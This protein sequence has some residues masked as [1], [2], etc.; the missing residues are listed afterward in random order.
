MTRPDAARSAG[1]LPAEV[2][3]FVGRRGETAAVTRLLGAHRLL[4]LTGG[5]GVGKTRLA[6]RVAAGLAPAFRDGVWLVELGPLQADM[7]L[8]ERVAEAVG[9]PVE[10]ARA[11]ERELAGFLGGKDLL[12]VLDN[13]EHVVEACRVL[14]SGLLGA[15]AE[16]RIVA[17]S[18]QPL[19]GA[20]EWLFEVPPLPVLDGEQPLSA[21]QVAGDGA[22]RLFT[23]RAQAALPG[24]TVG[25]ANQDTIVRLC[26]RLGGIPLAIELAAVHV[27]AMP[28]ERILARLEDQYLDVLG[29]GARAS[30]PRL[31]T[32]QASIDSSFD[33]CSK[34]EQRV[35]AR[36]SVFRGGFDLD[37]AQRVCSGAGVDRDEV[38]RVLAGLANKSVLTRCLVDGAGRYEM[39]EPLREYGLER[40]RAS[41]EAPMVRMRHRDHFAELAWQADQRL[42]S[43]AELQAYTAVSRNH[44]NLRAA[45]E[46]CLTEPDQAYVGLEIAASL[47]HY[48]IVSGHHREGGFWLDR[49][50]AAALEPTPACAKALW[51]NA[52]LACVQGDPDA[53]GPLIDH[54]RLLAQ[55][56]DDKV[57]CAYAALVRALEAFLCGDMVRGVE[58]LEDALV[59]WRELD[60]R[61]GVW[62]T[63]EYL[64]LMTALL[65]DADRARAFGEQYVDI[66]DASRGPLT[67]SWSLGIHGLAEWLAGDWQRAARLVRKSLATLPSFAALPWG[68]AH[69]FEVLAWD[70]AARDDGERAARLLGSAHVLWRFAATNLFRHPTT[71]TEHA[72]WEQHVRA[73]LGEQKFRAL[74]DEGAA[75]TTG[76]AI[77]YA[78]GDGT[79]N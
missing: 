71:A 3:S 53:A 17:T 48:W 60:D 52:W 2:T 78:L 74:F 40:L 44:A 6:L 62:T 63:L 59:R 26:E 55:L 13:C 67:R 4:T 77:A 41:G 50:L 11:P 75:F 29:A 31:Q 30:A 72:R 61:V 20:E 64:T 34:Q 22:V 79:Y 18:R 7:F 51:G 15:T 65:G 33:L 49:A 32:L 14:V 12:L 23:D 5:A 47:V 21:G 46:F 27:R 19:R 1:N 54:G 76:R 24:F 16:L 28:L 43:P 70:A 42:L 58:L 57:A 39:L 69:F 35:W 45:L 10:S 66:A 37:A 68:V 8:A 36:A 25:A 38:L 9:A 73:A 56:Q